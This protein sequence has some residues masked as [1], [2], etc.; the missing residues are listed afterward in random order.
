MSQKEINTNSID[1]NRINATKA[2][3][4]L[5]KPFPTSVITIQIHLMVHV[6]DEAAKVGVVH[7]RWMFFLQ[8]FMK[9][10]KS[11]VGQ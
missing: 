3:Y 8:R 4:M 2:T 7:S 11:F 9:T 10:L 6:V 5:E 1:V